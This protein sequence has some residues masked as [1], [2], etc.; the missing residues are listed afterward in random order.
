MYLKKDVKRTA[1]TSLTKAILNFVV[2]AHL[3]IQIVEEQSFKDLIQY[4][5][6]MKEDVTVPSSYMISKE[7]Q[8]TFLTLKGRVKK[9]L[10]EA[11]SVS[12]T[13]DGWSSNR[14]KKYL[15]I[16]SHFIRDE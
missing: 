3:P 14:G 4:V 6:D 10:A 12:L 1:T 16:T 11:E 5:H 9:W 7:L 8:R 15:A 13:V 2:K